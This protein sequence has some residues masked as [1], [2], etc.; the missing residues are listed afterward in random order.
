MLWNMFRLP[1]P[2]IHHLTL[3]H[4][5]LS[6]LSLASDEPLPE[7]SASWSNGTAPAAHG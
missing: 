4:T 6:V 5:P 3:R 7:R 2:D 1:T